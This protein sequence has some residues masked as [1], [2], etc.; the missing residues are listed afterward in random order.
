MLAF[1]LNIY[2]TNYIKNT[3][4]NTTY[5]L[6]IRRHKYFDYIQMSKFLNNNWDISNFT[7]GILKNIDPKLFN[8]TEVWNYITKKYPDA[9]PEKISILL[10]E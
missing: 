3:I 1:D 9:P 5:D 4:T 2:K 7:D 6:N 8:T 10:L